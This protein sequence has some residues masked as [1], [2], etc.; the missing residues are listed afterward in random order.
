MV[1][2][3][4]FTA[5]Y[6]VQIHLTFLPTFLQPSPSLLYIYCMIH[7]PVTVTIHNPQSCMNSTNCGLIRSVTETNWF[8]FT[9][10]SIIYEI[11]SC[12]NL[13]TTATNDCNHR[14]LKAYYF[15]EMPANVSFRICLSIS[16][17]KASRLKLFLIDKKLGS[18]RG[19]NDSV[20]L[21]T[22]FGPWEWKLTEGWRNLHNV[23][24]TARTCIS[25]HPAHADKMMPRCL[26][27]SS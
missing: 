14:E 22:I 23:S 26:P 13:G 6:G 2:S 24:L 18:H 15:R 4:T 12:E 3:L 19:R 20:Q 8:H 25:Y 7:R 27:P 10:R 17:P 5:R 9:W 21:T 11:I 1:T 16:Q